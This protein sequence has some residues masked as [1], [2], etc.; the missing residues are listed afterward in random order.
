LTL[1]A[2]AAL[3]MAVRPQ[4]EVVAT[5]FQDPRHLDIADGSLFVTDAGST[6]GVGASTTGAV[7]RIVVKHE[8]GD[9]DDDDDGKSQWSTKAEKII[10]DLDSFADEDGVSGPN[11]I[12]VRDGRLYL[13][14]QGSYLLYSATIPAVNGNRASNLG[15]L[16]VVDLRDD[17]SDDDDDHKRRELRSIA[18]VGAFSLGSQQIL[19]NLQAL[20]PGNTDPYNIEL[21]DD[22]IIYVADAGANM[23]VGVR[24]GFAWNIAFFPPT[25]VGAATDNGDAVPTS[26]TLGPDGFLYVA[27]L[28]FKHFFFGCTDGMGPRSNIYRIDP[29]AV[30]Y[31]ANHTSDV[32]A[33]GFNPITD[34]QYSRHQNAFYV[35]EFATLANFTVPGGEVVKVDVAGSHSNPVA[36]T[37]TPLGFGALTSPNGVV[38]SEHGDVFVTDCTG[39]TAGCTPRVVRVNH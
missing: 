35:V 34:L 9:D 29:K 27:T 22:G 30:G 31:V 23:L 38:V 5:G 25:C 17:D 33:A 13:Q 18:D 36:G 8:S 11:G 39:G 37:R 16:M 15:H 12:K 14:S 28:E 20:S 21:G 4:V 1:L 10:T 32:W 19:K 7:Y 6:T 2:L 26:V 3:A 24:N